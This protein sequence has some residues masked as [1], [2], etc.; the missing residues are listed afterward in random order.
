MYRVISIAL[1]AVMAIGCAM[2]A[3]S[4]KPFNEM[5]PKEKS[6]FIMNLYNKQYDDYLAI[7]AKPEKTL[8]DKAV[9]KQ[10]YELLVELHQ[11][12][13]LYVDY[14]ENGQIPTEVVEAGLIA[15]IEKILYK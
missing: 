2:F 11:Y 8:E 14:A 3:S 10:K 5:S 9:L 4:A 7:S 6:V 12:V 1:V 15:L 13:N